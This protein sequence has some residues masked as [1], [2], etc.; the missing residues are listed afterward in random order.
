[1]N[2]NISPILYGLVQAYESFYKSFA[3][4]GNNYLFS[5]IFDNDV[6]RDTVSGNTIK[7]RFVWG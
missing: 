2:K 4:A 7:K 3:S 1:V 5:Y 6:F